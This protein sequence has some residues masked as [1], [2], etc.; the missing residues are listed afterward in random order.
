MVA[1]QAAQQIID[2]RYTNVK[3]ELIVGLTVADASAKPL[4]L[5]FEASG[6]VETKSAFLR[7]SSQLRYGYH[8]LPFSFRPQFLL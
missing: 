4:A 8:N 1:R 3:E 5:P 7:S 2:L 6:N